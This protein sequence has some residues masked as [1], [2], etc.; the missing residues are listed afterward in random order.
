MQNKEK[1]RQSKSM[2]SIKWHGLNPLLLRRVTQISALLSI[3]L[4]PVLEV[5]RRLL[6]HLPDF[7]VGSLIANLNEFDS[8]DPL[9]KG[10]Y[11]SWLLIGIDSLFGFF[12]S[13]IYEIIRLLDQ[14]K[15]YFWSVTLGGLTIFDPLA[16]LQFIFYA[17]PFRLSFF[18]A[19][20]IPV[21]LAWIFGRVFCSWICP[22]N[23]LLEVLRLVH[24]KLK[25]PYLNYDLVTFSLL[26]YI[27]L[28]S[29]VVATLAGII[30]FPYILPYAV[31]GRVFYYMTISTV[32]LT[33]VFSITLI[34]LLDTFVQRGVWC[35]YLCPT[36]GLLNLLGWKRLIRLRRDEGKCIKEC[37]ACRSICQWKA[38]PKCE[39][40]M[41][42]TNCYRC[43][44]KCPS[45]A[46]K[47]GVK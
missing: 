40:I 25:L 42:C 1:N 22:I 26:R 45:K 39:Q 20:F 14:F 44:E 29:G 47:I 17:H 41:N 33:G 4:I 30:V 21:F 8:L 11:L 12:G 38:N 15:G 13:N 3:I 10:G 46:L 34:L 7:A 36:G 6:I 43:V 23:T 19:L 16:A 37:H 35:N 24:L 31:L 9:L 18:F 32:L 5:Y 27:L 28:G 2:F